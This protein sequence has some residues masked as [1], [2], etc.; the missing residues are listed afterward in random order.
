[1]FIYVLKIGDKNLWKIV[2][3]LNMEKLN[4]F[5]EKLKWFIIN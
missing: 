1:M 2:C 5:N 4:F 3:I